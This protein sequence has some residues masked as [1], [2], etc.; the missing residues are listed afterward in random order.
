M[1]G[2]VALGINDV[3][4]QEL[5]VVGDD[6]SVLP[7]ASSQQ[8]PFVNG[9]P[10]RNLFILLAAPA[11]VA[12]NASGGSGANVAPT[13]EQVGDN[14][15]ADTVF[16]DHF[17]VSATGGMGGPSVVATDNTP[18]DNPITE[19]GAGLG[20]LL[21]YD[22]GLSA[23][24]TIAC[25]SCHKAELGFADDA[26][27][28]LGF[29]GGETRRHSMALTNARFYEP[30]AYFWDQR[31]ATLEDQVLMPLQDEVEMGMTLDAVV[32][33]VESGDQY[34]SWFECA[35]GDDEVTSERVARALAQFVRSIV[36]F[37]SPY[38]QGRAQVSSALADFPNFTEEENLGKEIFMGTPMSPNGAGCAVCHQGEVMAASGAENN[39][40]DVNTSD[41][42][43]YGEVTRASTDMGTFKVP[44]LRN[45]AVRGKF[46]HDGRFETLRQVVDHYADS[47][48]PHPNLGMPL[49]MHDIE[50]SEA[51]RLALVAFLET[52]TD[53]RMLA[54]EKYSDPFASE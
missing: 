21:F 23:N 4:M 44:S 49:N 13:C 34:A 27:L 42:E 11:L 53:D 36:S 29:E 45:V 16:P 3:E 39:G 48:E 19:A 35:F 51:E 33:A 28:S 30:A 9:E 24:G 15:Y 26:T 7:P 32:A 54:A 12:C 40:L 2:D 47:V 8:L 10:M 17:T 22:T 50:L 6:A 52:L 46:M 14:D 5:T 41:D 37:E 31:A 1:S 38:D 18:A 25:A 43:G 20:R